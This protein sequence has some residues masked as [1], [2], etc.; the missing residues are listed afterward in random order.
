[1]HRLT[2]ILI[3]LSASACSDAGNAPASEKTPDLVPVVIGKLEDSH[4]REAS[5]L[6]RSQR[7]ENIL[8]VIN[9]NGAREWVHAINPRG[10]R[11][12]EFD[13]KKSK[14]KDWED[15]ASFRLDGIP[16]LMIA[17]IG[18]N[19]ARHKTRTLYF[20]E[21]PEAAKKEKEKIAWQVNF[22]YPNG[23]RDAEAAAVDVDN[24]RALVLSKRDIPPSLYELPLK[25]DSDKK[26]TAKW[27]GTI[28]SLP[29]PS[30]QDV[31]FAPKT[32][33]WHWQPVGMDISRDNLAAVILT[34]RA[35]YYYTRQPDQ[36]WFDALNTKPRRVSLGN[37]RNAEA[38][39]F[40]D[41]SRRVIV[42]GENRH[43]PILLIDFNEAP[44]E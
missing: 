28:R 16:Y 12:G 5:G 3:L 29:A 41:D 44:A 17:D 18:D 10:A 11:L 31:E 9:D 36:D 24:E 7:Q 4:I 2:P 20:V 8:W 39:A 30:R 40:G 42:T 33:D 35:V 15:L 19:D 43:S 21:E 1:M 6:A 27:L 38:I 14:N 32:K 22:K 13:L 37:F 26:V 23:P 34:Y 25:P